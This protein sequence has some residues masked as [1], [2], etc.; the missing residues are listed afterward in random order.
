MKQYGISYILNLLNISPSKMSQAL[1][2]DRTLVSK[3]KNAKRNVDTNN[4]YFDNLIDYLLLVNRNLGINS[5]ELFFRDYYNLNTSLDADLTKKYLITF[6]I[7]P[8]QITLNKQLSTTGITAIPVTIYNGL[9]NARKGI[10]DL[11]DMVYTNGIPSKITFIYCNVLLIYMEDQNFRLLWYEKL[12]K[13]LDRE[14]ELDLI[15]SSYKSTIEILKFT[16]LLLH[17]RFNLFYSSMMNKNSFNFSI[18]HFNSSFVLFSVFN[19]SEENY[20]NYS[21]LYQDSLSISAY[22]NIV[23]SIKSCSKPLFKSFFHNDLLKNFNKFDVYS[24]Q[25][26]YFS[27][28]NNAFYY[29]SIPTYLVME[30]DLFYEVLTQSIDNKSLITS[31]LQRYKQK[32]ANF[33]S[34][35][36]QNKTVHFYPINNLHKLAQSEKITY[37]KDNLI[38]TPPLKLTNTQYKNHLQN[39]VEFLHTHNNFHICLTVNESNHNQNNFHIWCRKNEILCIFDNQKPEQILISEDM[40]FVN[41][42]ADVLDRFYQESQ[43]E[44]KSKTSVSTILSNL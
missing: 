40:S 22:T 34:S 6:I 28:I 41:S 8:Y 39:L 18:H 5:L 14:F 25:H 17:D 31:E 10:L 36:S 26:T 33:L 24:K 37:S 11:L 2:I 3:W 38:S 29:N 23:Y 21:A 12:L 43:Q 27:A 1:N 35:L 19:N 9:E 20:C 16:S 42:I 7:N 30:E 32:K 44:L 13:L 15:I 4:E